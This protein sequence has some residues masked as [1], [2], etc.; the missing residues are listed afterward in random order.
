MSLAMAPE[1]SFISLVKSLNDFGFKCQETI[2]VWSCEGNPANYN[3]LPSIDISLL[4]NAQGSKAT[5]KMP[6]EGYL[7]FDPSQNIFFLLISPWQFQGLGGKQG[8]E[9][10][11]MGA[12]F[13]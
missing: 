11:V 3:S 4:L 5:V 8:E 10:W 7:K 1:K 2:P 12:Q 13:L 6:K 9:Y